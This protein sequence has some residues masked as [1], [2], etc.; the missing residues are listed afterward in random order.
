[1][2]LRKHRKFTEWHSSWVQKECLPDDV[3]KCSDWLLGV[4]NSNGS[5]HA[6]ERVSEKHCGHD[7]NRYITTFATPS[8]AM[9]TEC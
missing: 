5:E 8:A 1:M 3:K 7:R 6:T 4:A 2:V 9:A